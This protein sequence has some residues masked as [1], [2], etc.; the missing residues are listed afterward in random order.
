ME[1][2]RE[3]KITQIMRTVSDSRD[4]LESYFNFNSAGTQCIYKLHE[5]YF[6]EMRITIDLQLNIK[7]IH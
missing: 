4:L 7:T 6:P 2:L 5:L 3:Q 1:T